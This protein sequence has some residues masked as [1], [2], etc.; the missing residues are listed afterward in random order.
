MRYSFCLACTAALFA[1][2]S[3]AA[4]GAVDAEF[5]ATG[6]GAA[7]SKEVAAIRDAER[8]RAAAV[9]SGDIGTLRDLIGGEYYHVESNG[10][11]RTKTEFLQAL[12]RNELRI[13]GYGVDDMEITVLGSGRAAIVT[14]RFHAQVPGVQAPRQL[15]GR[16]VRVWTLQTDGW[17]N[18]LH[19]STEIRPAGTAAP[20]ARPLPLQ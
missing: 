11:V 16:Y 2:S 18:T 7:A 9:A 5:G 15:R 10:R 12:M 3:Y 8:R 6:G 14:G 4:A 1:A 19:Q 20:D 17:R 13:S